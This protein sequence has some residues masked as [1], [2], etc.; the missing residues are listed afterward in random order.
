MRSAL[1]LVLVLGLGPL[2]QDQPPGS[3]DK[4]KKPM[5]TVKATPAVAFSPAR[6]R[7]IAELKGGPDDYQEYYCAT[8]EWDWG[9]LTQSESG[10]DCEPYEA[11]VS[12]IVRRFTG[13]HTYRSQGRYRLQIRLKRNNRVLTAANTTI[14]VRAGVRDLGGL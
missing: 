4:S 6:V 3:G 2:A 7:A 12:Q 9:D 11:G 13:E 5:L 10:T 14:T 8:V 1:V